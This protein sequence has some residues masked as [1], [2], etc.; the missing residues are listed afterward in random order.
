MNLPR[1]VTTLGALALLACAAAPTSQARA[2]EPILVG[3][4][5]AQSGPAAFVGTP[6]RLVAE[7]AIEQ[8]NA[9]G[10]VLGRP[11]KL[12]VFDTESD[13]NLALRGAR[14]LNEQDRVLAIIGPT[15]TGSGLAVKKYTEDHKVPV[16]MTVGGDPVIAGGRFGHFNWTF[17]VPQ[18]TSTAIKKIYAHLEEAGI[19]RIGLLTANDGFGKDGAH[20]LRRL[21]GKHGLNIVADEVMDPKGSDFSAQAFKL[22]VAKPQAVIVWTIGPAGAIVT[23]NFTEQ[24]GDRPLIVQSHG[25]PG[26]KFV[27]LAG[28]AAEGVLMPGTKLMAPQALPDADPQK[29]V[30]TAFIRAYQ[31]RG[32]VEQFPVNTHSGYA[33]DAVLMLRQGLVA[34]NRAGREELRAALESLDGMIGVSGVF[35]TSP[36]DHNGLDTDS[37]L[38]LEVV[39]GDYVIAD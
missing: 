31:D 23:R 10:G 19:S 17:K 4:L 12:V 33:Y 18:R 38:M 2:A 14:K 37:L 13:A 34:A 39:D 28:P 32:L 25:Q 29:E 35:T 24:P 6:S 15:R 27:E 16:L 3:G 21:A 1:L 7:M 9:D 30:V 20:H 5:F 8:I 36:E 22:I 26:P 11:L